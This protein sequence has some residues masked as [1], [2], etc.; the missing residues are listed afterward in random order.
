[1]A[2]KHKHD[3]ED[4]T[5]SYCSLIHLRHLLS[6]VTDSLMAAQTVVMRVSAELKDREILFLPK[7]RGPYKITDADRKR[8]SVQL[9]KY[10][11]E[12]KAKK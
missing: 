1:M 5:C 10:Q 7:K 9:S 11:K 8:R 3:G 6:N 2:K 12:R 4:H